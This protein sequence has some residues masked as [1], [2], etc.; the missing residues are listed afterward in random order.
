MRNVPC[1]FSDNF[2]SSQRPALIQT[3]LQDNSVEAYDP[4]ANDPIWCLDRNVCERRAAVSD[5]SFSPLDLEF[6]SNAC[7]SIQNLSLPNV[8]VLP[9]L[10][11]NSAFTTVN[12]EDYGWNQ[13]QTKLPIFEPS[14]EDSTILAD[15][16]SANLEHPAIS[17]ESLCQL[18][19]D[20][21]KTT[22]HSMWE[23]LPLF[24][25]SPAAVMEEPLFEPS[26]EYVETLQYFIVASL[27]RKGPISKAIASKMPSEL[28]TANTPRK[29]CQ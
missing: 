27:N 23:D 21:P 29:Y 2:T 7:W 17:L 3:D 13:I 11:P 24:S 1:S 6:W 14:L 18:H 10:Q 16:F 19:K 9:A 20:L 26:L 5:F 22:M 15:N 28:L 4:T 12:M 8:G 25:P